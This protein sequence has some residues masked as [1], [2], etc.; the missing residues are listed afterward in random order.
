MLY[1]QKY[2]SNLLRGLED[3][4]PWNL[5]EV[6]RQYLKKSDTLLDIGCGTAFKLIQLSNNVKKIYGLEP[7]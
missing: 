6:I 1:G 3:T 7:S 5:L 4:R 2:E